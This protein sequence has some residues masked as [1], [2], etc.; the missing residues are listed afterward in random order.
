MLYV[1]ITI[2]METVKVLPARNRRRKLS[3]SRFGHGRTCRVELRHYDILMEEVAIE[4]PH[5]YKNFTRC[6]KDLFDEVVLITTPAVRRHIGLGTLP[7]AQLP[8]QCVVRP[9]STAWLEHGS[10]VWGHQT[11]T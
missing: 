5:F 10:I 6:E 8:M 4:W 11:V 2:M 3:K 9:R 7:A 1:N